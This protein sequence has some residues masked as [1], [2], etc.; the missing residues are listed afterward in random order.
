MYI[1]ESF[2]HFH[3]LH[4]VP[5]TNIDTR[6]GLRCRALNVPEIILSPRL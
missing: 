5:V 3:H 2:V 4:I 1:I 6:L